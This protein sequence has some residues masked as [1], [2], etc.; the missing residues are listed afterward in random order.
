[1]R[2]SGLHYRLDA[3]RS[4]CQTEEEVE[5]KFGPEGIENLISS[6]FFYSPEYHLHEGMTSNSERTVAILINLRDRVKQGDISYRT[7]SIG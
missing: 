1:M 3:C 4:G 5:K 7:L 2:L 6:R